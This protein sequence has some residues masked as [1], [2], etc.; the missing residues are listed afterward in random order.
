MNIGKIMEAGGF[1]LIVGSFLYALYQDFFH[2]ISLG[3]NSGNNSLPY[4]LGMLLWS[5]GYMMNP[6]RKKETQD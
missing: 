1:L 5:L 4:I 3:D 2:D 6:D